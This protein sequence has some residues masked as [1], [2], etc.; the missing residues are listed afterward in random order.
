LRIT[1][2]SAAKV[3]SNDVFGRAN[4]PAQYPSGS[5]TTGVHR[6]CLTTDRNDCVE[7]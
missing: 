6:F 4:G 3:S 2:P 5:P 7:A 1:S